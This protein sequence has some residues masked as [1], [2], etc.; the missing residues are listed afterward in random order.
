MIANRRTKRKM[1]MM[2]TKEEAAVTK[3]KK[4]KDDNPDGEL[5]EDPGEVR[6]D[7]PLDLSMVDGGTTVA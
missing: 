7:I 1:G 2:I 5:G 6:K 4:S 3:A